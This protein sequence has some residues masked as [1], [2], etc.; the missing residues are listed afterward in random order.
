MKIIALVYPW[1]SSIYELA[2][3]NVRT[4]VRNGKDRKG[5]RK[6]QLT[7]LTS[8]RSPVNDRYSISSRSNIF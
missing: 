8:V 5:N 2:T 7:I 3:N 1:S 4:T 6:V